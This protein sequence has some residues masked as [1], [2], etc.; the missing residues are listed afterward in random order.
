M[1]RKTYRKTIVTKELLEQIN[2]INKDLMKKFLKEKTTRSSPTTIK[3][4]T[5]SANIFFVY[6]LIYNEN[7]AFTDI[8]KL[9]FSD[10]FSFTTEELKWGSARN[11][12]VRS[13]LSSLS[14][15]IEKFLDS[16]YPGFRNIVLKTIESIPKEF[17]REKTVLS[18]EQ[19]ENLL[20]HLSETDSQHACWLSL[21]AYSGSR[22]S[23]LLRFTV[24]LID[25]NNTAF[26]DIFL[27]TTR[28]IP[29]KGRG[30]SG[31]LLL[32]YIIKDKYLPY[33]RKWIEDRK[34]IIEKNKIEDHG[35][36]FIKSDGSPA[37]EGTIRSWVSTM[38]SW[39]GINLYPHALRHFLVSEFSRRKIP[40]NLTKDIVG[41]ESESMVALYDDTS[42]K[43]REW[44]ELDNLKQ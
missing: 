28:K 41:W 16:E 22:F 4:Y 32:K 18:N 27:E 17:R 8:T 14:I 15:F 44:K 3:N 7:K 35:F 26:G 42:S 9:E 6:N 12:G 25:E 36:L 19:V 39:L 37:V 20:R 30:K 34:L 24:D 31:K 33:H 5:S 38:E 23:E 43:D 13:L 2:P 40:T 10:F 29:T 11:N 21:A 1:S